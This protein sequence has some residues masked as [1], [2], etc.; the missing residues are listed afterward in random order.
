[1]RLALVAKYISG[2]FFINLFRKFAVE[3]S[4]SGVDVTILAGAEGNKQEANP[5]GNGG[6]VEEVHVPY[7]SVAIHTS[8]GIVTYPS[9][10][11]DD[12]LFARSVS[13]ELGERYDLI[14]CDNPVYAH[15]MG[16]SGVRQPLIYNCIDGYLLKPNFMALRDRLLTRF[17]HSPMEMKAA[18][19]SDYVVCMNEPVRDFFIERSVSPSKLRV[20]PPISTVDADLFRPV[21]GGYPGLIEKYRMSGK[22]TIVFVGRLIYIKGIDIILQATKLLLRDG[23]G[24]KIRVLIVGPFSDI[25]AYSGGSSYALGLLKFLND[26]DLRKVVTFTGPLG[27]DVLSRLLA[28][29]DILVAPSRLEGLG[30]VLLEAMSCGLPVVGS[31]VGGIPTVIDDG[32]EG[33]LFNPAKPE[34]L[35]TK[36]KVLIENGY[37]RRAFGMAGREK[38]L[39][40]YALKVVA[41]QYVSL[42][43][44]MVG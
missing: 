31:K 42:Y 4:N 17:Y 39:D 40:R 2:S 12:R 1:M 26:P 44:E 37:L 3:V 8:A 11:V 16:K 38:V 34:E 19:A 14:Q 5:F 23:Y 25:Q 21:Q 22:C 10:M 30:V 9:W 32:K 35:A 43:R 20:I 24:G 18:S 33:Y 28:S 36:L 27:H 13:R 29:S 15:Y 41:R 6:H 7:P